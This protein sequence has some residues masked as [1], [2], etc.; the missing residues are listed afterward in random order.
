MPTPTN[1][2]TT[3]PAASIEDKPRAAMNAASSAGSSAAVT[4]AIS[5]ADAAKA[6]GARALD[7]FAVCPYVATAEAS[8]S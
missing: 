7:N 1:S 4:P 8:G 5:K 6:G 3:R 2:S